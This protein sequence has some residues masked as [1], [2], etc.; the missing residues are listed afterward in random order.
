M[1]RYQAE[2]Q[3]PAMW[4][5]CGMA[6]AFFGFILGYIVANQNNLQTQFGAPL[7]AAAPAAP[8]GGTAPPLVDE[9]EIQIYRDILAR[10]PKNAKAATRLG[11]LL[12]DSQRYSEAI[13]YYE[14]ALSLE[15]GNVNVST[16]LG[17]AL[18]YSGRP[19]AALAQYAKSLSIQPDHPNTLFNIGIVRMQGKQDVRGAIESWERLVTTNPEYPEIAKVQQRLAEARQQLGAGSPPMP[20]TKPAGRRP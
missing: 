13:P 1:S 3:S 7:A 10:D 20:A 19:D 2:Y 11:D 9:R 17:T 18:W 16:D 6:G 5:I 14:Q 12:Y 15:P 4:V 8:G